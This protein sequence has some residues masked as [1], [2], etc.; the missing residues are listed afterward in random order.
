MNAP[1]IKSVLPL[2]EWKLLVTFANDVQKIY[3]CTPLFQ[4]ERFWQLRNEAFFKS[5]KVDV[6][7][8]GVSWNDDIDLSEYE[9]WHN[10]IEVDVEAEA[11]H[12]SGLQ[13]QN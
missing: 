12:L 11:L 5:L 1:K 8:Y 13:V 7:G 3:D 4:Q 9:L 2:Q 6:G 10:G